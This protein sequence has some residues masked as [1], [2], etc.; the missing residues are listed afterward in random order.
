MKPPLASPHVESREPRSQRGSALL[1]ALIFA[2]IIGVTLVSSISLSNQSL[3]V[4]HRTFFADAASNLAET[5]LEEA[6]WS[7]NQMGLSTNAT[8][9]A[10]SWSG[11]TLG[12]AIADVAMS[13]LGDGYS[14]APTV[15]FSGGG[16][17]GAAGTAVL[18]TS[19]EID[20][21]S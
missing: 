8:T 7:F 6:V 21:V 4:A 17:S 18:T 11:W 20:T 10:N 13:A 3:K 16:G 14:S 19:T 15:S 12:S 9:I 1:T 2:I 5:G